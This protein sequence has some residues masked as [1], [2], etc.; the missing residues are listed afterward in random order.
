MAVGSAQVCHAGQLMCLALNLELRL[1][2]EFRFVNGLIATVLP[3][4][5]ATVLP[6]RIGTVL[7]GAL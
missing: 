6:K 1:R 4:R 7:P 5:I 3:G 2:A